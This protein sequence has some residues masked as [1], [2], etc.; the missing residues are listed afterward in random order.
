MV[1][2]WKLKAVRLSKFWVELVWLLWLPDIWRV[3]RTLLATNRET[4]WD[5]GFLQI[6]EA[7]YEVSNSGAG[8]FK[9]HNRNSHS[10]KLG[11]ACQNTTQ[12]CCRFFCLV[13]FTSMFSLYYLGFGGRSEVISFSCFIVLNHCPSSFLLF[14]PP[15]AY[16]AYA[17]LCPM[18]LRSSKILHKAYAA[19]LRLVPCKMRHMW[20]ASVSNLSFVSICSHLKKTAH[21]TNFEK[22]RCFFWE[23]CNCHAHKIRSA[24]GGDEACQKIFAQTLEETSNTIHTFHTFHTSKANHPEFAPGHFMTLGSCRYSK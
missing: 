20:T 14:F 18:C 23:R 24:I 7:K 5:G 9:R 12:H 22:L 11:H 21:K 13:M 10:L 2:R 4:S 1:Q 17:C 19:K 16:A 3:F 8:R 15:Y 6:E